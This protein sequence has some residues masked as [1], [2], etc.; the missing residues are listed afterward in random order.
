[1]IAHEEITA[2]K[3]AEDALH[4]T[5]IEVKR[6]DAQM[7]ALNQMNDLL[8]S[9]ETREEA[10]AIIAYSAGALFT[11]YAGGLAVGNGS[12]TDLRVVA[13]W[14]DADRLAPF[15]PLRDCWGLRLG[16]LHEVGLSGDEMDCRHFLDYPPPTYLCAP[17]NVRGTTLGL[18][19]VNTDAVLTE[20]QFHELRMLVMTVSESI[21]LALSNLKL[22]EVLRSCTKNSI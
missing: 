16:K 18:L 22:Q 3:N 17:L 19:Q 4:A 5:L 2:R 15:F 12:V 11:P 13:V 7:I 6:H 10:Y 8:L 20:T 1:M 14:G 9:C 21:K